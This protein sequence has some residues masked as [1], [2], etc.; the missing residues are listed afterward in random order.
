VST[1]TR[2]LLFDSCIPAIVHSRIPASNWY[3]WC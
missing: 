3:Q 2:E 1:P